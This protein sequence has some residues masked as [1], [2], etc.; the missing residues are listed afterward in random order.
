MDAS[1]IAAFGSGIQ[2]QVPGSFLALH[3]SARMLTHRGLRMMTAEEGRERRGFAN[4]V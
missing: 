3:P 1:K 4:L 2:S